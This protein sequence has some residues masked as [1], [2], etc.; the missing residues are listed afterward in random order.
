MHPPHVLFANA[1]VVVGAFTQKNR[2]L[3][4]QHARS[5]V[6]RKDLKE[7]RPTDSTGWPSQEASSA[8]DVA[9]QHGRR[10]HGQWNKAGHVLEAGQ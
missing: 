2:R 7:M 9:S 3:G 4:D 10:L 1:N 6:L 5:R 8:R